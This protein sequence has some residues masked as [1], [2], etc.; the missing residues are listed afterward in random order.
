MSIKPFLRYPLKALI[1]DENNNSIEL[2]L[3][4]AS[5]TIKDLTSNYFDRIFFD[6]FSPKNNPDY[7]VWKYFRNCTGYLRNTDSLSTYSCAGWI[8]RNLKQAGFTVQDGPRIGRRS[9]ATIAH[10]N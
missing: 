5:E 3:G 9:P 7:G 10:K 6:P 4:D 1:K 8:R 2:I